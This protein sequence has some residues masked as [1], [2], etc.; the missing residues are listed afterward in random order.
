MR[1]SHRK[2]SR[3]VEQR[4]F[5]RRR[6]ARQANT[7]KN[8]PWQQPLRLPGAQSTRP[9][10]VARRWKSYR[11]ILHISMKRET[12]PAKCAPPRVWE[13]RELR[14][15]TRDNLPPPSA[16]PAPSSIPPGTHRCRCFE[17]LR[18]VVPSNYPIKVSDT[19]SKG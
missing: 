1:G 17:M 15:T 2:F 5:V 18:P 11:G 9:A 13:S 7:S 10:A 3:H 6:S 12:K 4:S 14:Q 16:S 8:W 19:R